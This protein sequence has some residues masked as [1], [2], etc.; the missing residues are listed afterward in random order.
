MLEISHKFT[1]NVQCWRFLTS[2]RGMYNVG[3]FSQVYVECT[4]LE[5]ANKFTWNVQCSKLKFL[6][7][8]PKN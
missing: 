7:F 1:W 8:Q 5:I 3:D 6:K 2:L 4:M